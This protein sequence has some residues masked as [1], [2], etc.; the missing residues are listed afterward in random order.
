MKSRG[1]HSMVLISVNLLLLVAFLAHSQI[2]AFGIQNNSSDI[3]GVVKN[4]TFIIAESREPK[5]LTS[6]GIVQAAPPET[7]LI[8]VTQ[9]EGKALLVSSKQMDNKWIWGASI[10]EIADPVLTKLVEKIYSLK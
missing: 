8:N 10:V 1:S 5:K 7:G 3:L 2:F 6:V 9:Y 4:G